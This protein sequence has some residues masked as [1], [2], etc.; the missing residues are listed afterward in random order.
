MFNVHVETFEINI[1][2]IVAALSV[3]LVV[4]PSGKLV[5]QITWKLL[6]AL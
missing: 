6:M 2:H 5:R 3:L 1:K 4:H